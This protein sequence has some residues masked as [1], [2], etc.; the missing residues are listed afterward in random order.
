MFS[1]FNLYQKHLGSDKLNFQL[2]HFIYI[3]NF[4]LKVTPE[5]DKYKW[6]Q[7]FYVG[8]NGFLTLFFNIYLFVVCLRGCLYVKVGGK[9]AR[10][11]IVPHPWIP[12]IELSMPVFKA[13]ACIH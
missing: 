1:D 3:H 12:V 9:L 11:N 4:S 10:V 8:K 2:F 7:D 6:S 13:S 5:L